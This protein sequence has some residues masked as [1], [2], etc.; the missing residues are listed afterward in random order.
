MKKDGL[1]KDLKLQIHRET[2][3]TLDEPLLVGAVIGGATI[4][5][6]TYSECQNSIRC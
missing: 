4:F 6:S 2:L 1:K 5:P 3:R